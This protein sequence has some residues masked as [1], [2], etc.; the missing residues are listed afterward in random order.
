MRLGNLSD[1]LTVDVSRT[2]ATDE[3]KQFI[4]SVHT[5]SGQKP[6]TST[7]FVLQF[8]ATGVRTLDLQSAPGELAM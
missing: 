4:P 3:G 6:K 1:T 5:T 8:S 2:K 7:F